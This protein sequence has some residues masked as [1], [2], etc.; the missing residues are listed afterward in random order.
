VPEQEVLSG[1]RAFLAW[2][3]SPGPERLKNPDVTLDDVL[4]KYTQG[5]SEE[6]QKAIGRHARRMVKGHA[7]TS[8]DEPRDAQGKC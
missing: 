4:K 6:D 3:N 5:M 1:V 8:A 7:S 2:V